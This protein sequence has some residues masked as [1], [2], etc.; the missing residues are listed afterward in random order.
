MAFA[1]SYT[2]LARFV[3]PET[4]LIRA[5][6]KWIVSFTNSSQV[7]ALLLLRANARSLCPAIVYRTTLQADSYLSNHSVPDF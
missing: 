5:K 7:R 2:N 1:H 6:E 3:T 4:R